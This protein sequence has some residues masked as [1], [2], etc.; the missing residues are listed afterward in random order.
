MRMF[1]NLTPFIPLSF[2]GEGEGVVFE[3]ALPLFDTPLLFF[4]L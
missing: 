1:I 4:L 2:K 3:G